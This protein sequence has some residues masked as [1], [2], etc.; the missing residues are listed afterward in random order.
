M[1]ETRHG[2]DMPHGLRVADLARALRVPKPTIYRWITTGQLPAVVVGKVLIVL[3]EDLDRFL[4]E[5]RVDRRA[6]TRG[7]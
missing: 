5:K 4:A 1:T 3:R 2:D 6:D 7:S